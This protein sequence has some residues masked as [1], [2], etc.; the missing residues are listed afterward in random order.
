MR[1][2]L[3][4]RRPG[5]WRLRVVTGYRPDGQARQASRTVKGTRRQAQDALNAFLVEVQT[6]A[7]P[8]SGTLKFGAYL[9]DK[10]LPHVKRAWEIETYRTTRSRIE[11]RI[12][13]ALGAVRLDKL[14]AR[15]LDEA[16]RTWSEEGLRPSTIKAHHQTISSA[17]SQA[18]KWQLIPRSV[19]TLA[20]V[21]RVPSRSD[22]M[23]SVEQIKVLVAASSDADPTLSAA[24]MTAALTGARRSEL[25]ALRWSDI[26][27]ESM[28]LTIAHGV[29]R[30]GNGEFV[31]GPTKNHQV[32]RLSVDTLTLAVLDAHHEYC[33]RRATGGGAVLADDAFI[34]S[35]GDPAGRSP[36]NPDVLS[37][38]F[39][40]L[41]R[42][43]GLVGVRFHDLRHA[44]ASTLLASGF[45]LAVVAGR[46]GHSQQM[47]LQVYAHA[48]EQRDREAAR[49]MSELLMPTSF[50]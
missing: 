17:L 31:L 40:R 18:V 42:Q 50:G 45:D 20:T 21:P 16:Y 22:S 10:Y 48:L 4:E 9:K 11:G 7:A 25:L 32:R 36:S 19:A 28:T 37:N 14:G 6:G 33:D 44:A 3:S 39:A 13:P 41:A 1:G 29:K 43:A 34:F 38:R 46:L 23:P 27:L 47:L 8:S 49:V 35:W 12:I 15:D 2:T 30:A 26:D 5:V 24:I